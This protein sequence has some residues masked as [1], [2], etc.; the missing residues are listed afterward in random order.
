[1]RCIP[2]FPGSGK[3]RSLQKAGIVPVLQPFQLFQILPAVDVQQLGRVLHR[4]AADPLRVTPDHFAA[5]PALGQ[6]GQLRK[7]PRREEDRRPRKS[8]AKRS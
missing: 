5:S 2:P 3:A 8:E 6:G 4:D 7:G 1:M